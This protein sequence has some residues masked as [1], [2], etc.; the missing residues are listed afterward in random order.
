V[1]FLLSHQPKSW[2]IF[3]VLDHLVLLFNS[4]AFTKHVRITRCFLFLGKDLYF[5]TSYQ[6]KTGRRIVID[7]DEIFRRVVLS[8]VLVTRTKTQQSIMVSFS[9][10]VWMGCLRLERGCCYCLWSDWVRSDDGHK[11]IMDEQRNGLLTRNLI[12]TTTAPIP[13]KLFPLPARKPRS[14]V[15]AE[16]H[17]NEIYLILLLLSASVTVSL[18]LVCVVT[19]RPFFMAINKKSTIM[20][21]SSSVHLD[22]LQPPSCT[23]SD[24]SRPSL[25]LLHF[26]MPLALTKRMMASRHVDSR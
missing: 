20:V 4:T 25:S 1:C 3:G 11:E 2:H 14:V 10:A 5:F 26:S 6:K 8:T 12:H 16:R 22:N 24:T 18:R 17:R 19:Y 15:L 9:S 13:F 21:T 7:L 23:K